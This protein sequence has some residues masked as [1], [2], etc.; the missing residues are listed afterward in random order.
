MVKWSACSSSSPTISVRIPLSPTVFL[1]KFVIEKNENKL[2][3]AGGWPIKKEKSKRSKMK[4]IHSMRITNI[5]QECFC[6]NVFFPSQAYI[7]IF[8]FHAFYAAANLI[9]IM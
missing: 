9:A 6:E 1:F 8:L 3:E 2:K 7:F 5:L 4:S